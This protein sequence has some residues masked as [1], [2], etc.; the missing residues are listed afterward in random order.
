MADESMKSSQAVE[1]KK[2]TSDKQE[3]SPEQQEKFA[4]VIG[5]A[6]ASSEVLRLQAQEQGVTVSEDSIQTTFILLA[7][8]I[9]DLLEASS[10]D[11][12]P[13]IVPVPNLGEKK[14]AAYYK[15][16]ETGRH[17]IIFSSEK[18][19]KASQ[20]LEDAT[21]DDAEIQLITDELAEA[22]YAIAHEMGHLR[23]GEKLPY[24]QE[25]EAQ[26]HNTDNWEHT[27]E[28]LMAYSNDLAETNAH[29][30]AIRYLK[31]KKQAKQESPLWQAMDFSRVIGRNIE[32]QGRYKMLADIFNAQK[33]VGERNKATDMET[34]SRLQKRAELLVKRI[35]SS[36]ARLDKA[37]ERIGSTPPPE[38]SA[39]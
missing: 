35:Q 29:A 39:N 38:P 28:N 7:E 4:K 22:V 26:E 12:V 8:V 18:I 10:V 30:I 34:Y 31:A 13:Y 15:D 25:K 33:T 36:Y 37:H 6:L 9:Y 14:I 20:V 5:R 23:Q 19:A 1:W 3:L 11:D 21:S 24:F 32:A 27:Q 16:N 17:I 2:I